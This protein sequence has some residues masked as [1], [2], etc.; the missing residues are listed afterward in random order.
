MEAGSS[1]HPDTRQRWCRQSRTFEGGKI[2]PGT[3][4]PS[5]IPLEL[6]CDMPAKRGTPLNAEAQVF[7]PTRQAAALAQERIRAMIN[8]EDKD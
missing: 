2:L 5:P 4:N 3:S 8:A 6:T 7:R 1:R